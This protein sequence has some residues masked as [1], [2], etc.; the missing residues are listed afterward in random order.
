MLH[1]YGL[2]VMHLADVC[3]LVKKIRCRRRTHTVPTQVFLKNLHT[4]VSPT[5]SFHS[6]LFSH[7]STTAPFHKPCLSLTAFH[8]TEDKF[9]KEVAQFQPVK[10]KKRHFI[11]LLH[12]CSRGNL[13]KD[14]RHPNLEATLDLQCALHEEPLSLCIPGSD[15]IVVNL[16]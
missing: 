7:P 15:V 4:L 13:L 8:P 16:I 10:N 14:S 5:L 12:L 1:N 9:W 2:K 3:K 11:D 6:C